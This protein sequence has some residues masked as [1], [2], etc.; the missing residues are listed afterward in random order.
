MTDKTAGCTCNFDICSNCEHSGCC[1]DARP[2]LT[3]ER[4][5]IIAKYLSSHG[6]TSDKV[7]SHSGYSFPSVTSN[8]FCIFYDRTTKLCGIHLV[9][10]ETCR[11]G[12]IT[13]DINRATKK[14]EW[15]LKKSEICSFAGEL[16]KNPS[17]LAEHLGLAKEEIMKLISKLDTEALETILSRDEPQTFKIGEDQLPK[18]VLTKLRLD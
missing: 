1:L 14:L 18:S 9:K 3:A 17:K 8:E 13:F 2:P 12:P 5:T 16:W 7:F 6:G 10:P 4:I 11:A 15:F